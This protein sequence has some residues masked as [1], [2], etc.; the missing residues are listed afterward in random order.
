MAQLSH[1][2]MTTGKTN[3][4][5]RQIFVSKVISL[6]FNMVSTLQIAHSV[7][8]MGAIIGGILHMQK[9]RLVEVKQIGHIF[10]ERNTDPI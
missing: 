1:P 10:T 4:L 6:L 2:Y 7:L 5:T 8:A 3:A 9:L